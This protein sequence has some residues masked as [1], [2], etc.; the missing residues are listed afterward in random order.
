M[1]ELKFFRVL[2][3]AGCSLLSACAHQNALMQSPSANTTAGIDQ[4][5]E[6]LDQ[7]LEKPEPP[8]LSNDVLSAL[9]PGIED[10]SSLA[11][12]PR[13]DI[14]VDRVPAAEFFAGLVAGTS[15]NMVVHPDVS[16]LISL[17]LKNVT[18]EEV[19]EVTKEI[20]GYEYERK[21]RLT[22][23]FA[24]GMRTRIFHIDYLDVVRRGGSETSVSSGQITMGPSNN[25]DSDDSSL[26]GN[27]QSG[28]ASRGTQINTQSEHSFWSNLQN[29]LQLIIGSK[30]GNSVVLTPSAGVIVVRADSESLT[31]VENYLRRAELIMR[32]QVILEAKILEVELN[33]SYQQGIDWT[34]A[35]AGEFTAAGVARRSI[36]V[37]LDARTVANAVAGGGGVFSSTVRLGNFTTTIDLLGTQGNV[38][39]LSSPRISTVNN[40]K[41][42]IKVGKDEYFVTDID[43]ESNNDT[44]SNSTDIELT[45]FFSGI[46]LDVTPQISED[47]KIVLH[48]HPSISSVE[49]QQKIIS[50]SGE[51][52][53]LPLALSTIRESDSVITAENGQIVVIGGLIQTISSDENSSVPFLSEIPLLGELFKQKSEKENKTELVILL[54]PTITDDSVYESDIRESRERFGKFRD[55]MGQAPETNFYQ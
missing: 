54:R 1:G 46:A 5:N 9:T 14:S 11:A 31:A 32:R 13:F 51:D 12:E 50:I 38:Q 44:N 7:I 24:T 21:D 45:P 42:V 43:F 29:T 17:N 2:V 33:Q 41:A 48:V 23:V 25:T 28:R 40:Q 10:G 26:G 20:Y 39:V 49:D 3:M 30:E 53:D 34:F 4:I 55:Q 22:K 19:L 27:S 18:V 16:G 6:D 8:A 36:D 37:G 35:E 47:G 52:I 15:E